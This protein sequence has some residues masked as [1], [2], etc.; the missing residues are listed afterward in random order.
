[1][2][3]L[4]FYFVKIPI[5]NFVVHLNLCSHFFLLCEI[6]IWKFVLQLN[7][8]SHFLYFVESNLKFCSSIKSIFTIS[9]LCKI[10]IWYFVVHLNLCSHFFFYF[11][12]FPIWYFVVHLNIYVHTFFTLWN[13]NLK[14][15]S[16]F[17]SMFTLSFFVKFQCW[18]V[19]PSK[20]M[21]ILFFP[22]CF[23]VHPQIYHFC[24][25]SFWKEKNYVNNYYEFFFIPVFWGVFTRS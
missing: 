25:V 17:K 15:W 5:W 4:S 19:S 12:K 6:P 23:V 20:S 22:F 11:V 7:L 21:F 18:I 3:T 10:P 9:L 16:S 2:F 8:C 13:F 14:I 1:M 24:W